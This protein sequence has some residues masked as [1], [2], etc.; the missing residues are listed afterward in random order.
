MRSLLYIVLALAACGRSD[1][2]R[3][4]GT[5]DAARDA[6]A[7]DTAPAVVAENTAVAAPQPDITRISERLLGTWKAQGVDQGSTRPQKFTIIWTDKP[8][9]E[10]TGTI[11]FQPGESYDV[12]VV[13]ATD[14]SIVYQSEPH[15]S[16]TLKAQV[17][18]R[19]EARLV[20]DSL[21][22]TYEAKATE[23]DKVLK[24]RF[25][26]KRGSGPR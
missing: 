3:D 25:T 24:G 17:V 22:G 1:T 21:V 5:G 2:A 20:G 9:G 12:E 19:T 10:L 23:G 15:N 7:G 11:V 16:P 14:S 6:G 18:T 8:D 26:A 13:S 4:T